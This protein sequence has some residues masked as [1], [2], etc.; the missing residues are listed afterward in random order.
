[1]DSLPLTPRRDPGLTAA[2]TGASPVRHPLRVIARG[3]IAGLRRVQAFVAGFLIGMSV[4]TP[5]FVATAAEETKWEQ[6]GLPG[7]FALFT[8][9]VWLRV[10]NFLR[11]GRNGRPGDPGNPTAGLGG[12]ARN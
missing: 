2:D 4:W 11:R 3:I 7:G 9:G 8:A 6:F 1:M 10:G 12:F 5:L